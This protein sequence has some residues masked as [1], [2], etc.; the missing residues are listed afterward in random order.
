M[1]MRTLGRLLRLSL[2]ATACADI[3]AG[4]VLGAGF[5]PGG[6][7]PWVLII[8]SLSVYHGGMALNDWADRSHDAATRPDRPI[9]AGRVVPATALALSLGLVVLGP[10]LAA[11]VDPRSGVLLATVAAL[12]V[13]Y[14]LAGRGPRLGPTLLG[15]CRALNV[16]CGVTY[17]LVVGTHPA[18]GATHAVLLGL[19]FAYGAYVFVVSC[20]GRLEDGEDGLRTRRIGPRGLLTAA[21]LLLLAPSVLITTAGDMPW[22]AE[23]NAGIWSPVLG[24]GIALAGALGLLQRALQEKDWSPARIGAVMG[25]ALR[26]LLVFTS[27][28]AILFGGRDGLIVGLLILAGYP[29][30]HALRKVFP[31][32]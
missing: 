1:G 29:V 18:D 27:S 12:A 28:L 24:I 30:S 25:M 6:A 17:G 8:A 23:R 22:I 9:P 10:L 7:G 32:S 31:P 20:L 13:F 4:I 3:A 5:W 21:A 2:S 11:S 16:S 19:P 26:R 14:D 15:L